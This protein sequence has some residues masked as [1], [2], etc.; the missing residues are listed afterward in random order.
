MST[1]YAT[2]TTTRTSASETFT[3]G[4]LSS[5]T[6]TLPQVEVPYIPIGTPVNYRIEYNNC[7][8]NVFEW[9]H[10]GHYLGKIIYLH[11]F[12][13][14]SG[15]YNQWFDRLSQAGYEVFFYEQ[16]GMGETSHGDEFGRTDGVRQIDDLDY[17]IEYNAARR[18]ILD[19]KFYIMGFSMGAAMSIDYAVRGKHKD[20]IKCIVASAPTTL[21]HP[22]VDIPPVVHFLAPVINKCA[23]N[24]RILTT[25][26]KPENITSNLIWQRYIAKFETDALY[27]TTR[28]F[29]DLFERG[30]RIISK[31][32][33]K[34]FP[35][36]IALL[37]MHGKEDRLN[38]IEG[39]RKLNRALN[40]KIAK[41]Y[42]EIPG[43]L[44]HLYIERDEIQDY[45]FN[46]VLAFMKKYNS[47]TAIATK[48]RPG[49][50]TSFM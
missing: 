4:K 50:R 23:P 19:E 29:H 27:G 44:H 15:V 31:N 25:R 33:A 24:I 37:V 35:A 10:H 41:E 13:E 22:D 17:M 39:S 42:I 21:L 40:S 8:F 32:H 47:E 34:K 46:K 9:P 6:T 5:K 2:P 38:W 11:G 14:H 1:A 30:Q 48:P 20:K 45:V 36:T 3:K 49:I 12:G 43:A 16:R 26:I 18:F 28:F 7:S